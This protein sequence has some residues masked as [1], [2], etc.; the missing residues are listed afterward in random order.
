MDESRLW[1]I[2]GVVTAVIGLA[3]FAPELAHLASGETHG[4]ETVMLAVY[5]AGVVLAVV[6]TAVVILPNLRNGSA[7]R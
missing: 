4:L 7:P 6:V 2:L 5:S 1:G 3:V